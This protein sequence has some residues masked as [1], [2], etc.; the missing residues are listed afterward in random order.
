MIRTVILSII[1]IVIMCS[2]SYASVTIEFGSA[3]SGDGAALSGTTGN[4]SIDLRELQVTDTQS[5][6]LL[7]ASL[8]ISPISIDSKNAAFAGMAEYSISA[9]QPTAGFQMFA[10]IDGN[11]SDELIMS[12][13][14]FVDSL[15]TIGSGAHISPVPEM[16]ITNITLHNTNMMLMYWLTIPSELISF[17]YVGFGELTVDLSASPHIF[18]SLIDSGTNMEFIEVVGTLTT[19][20][21]SVPE[22]MA[23]ALFGVGAWFLRRKVRS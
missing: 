18:G 14:L 7:G 11:G 2:I 3:P 8:T 5:N 20:P 1:N 21:T 22:P 13:D 9:M 10:D 19:N 23:F 12:G 15:I 17:E 16:D 4:M 6:L